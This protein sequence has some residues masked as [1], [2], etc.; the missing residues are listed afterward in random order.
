MAMGVSDQSFPEI[1]EGPGVKIV[2]TTRVED[3]SFQ[4][5]RTIL[6]QPYL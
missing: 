5:L 6:K 2:G 1:V 4:S 3:A